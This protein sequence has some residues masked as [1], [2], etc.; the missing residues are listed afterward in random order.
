MHVHGH[1]HTYVFS[2]SEIR[3]QPACHFLDI[4]HLENTYTYILKFLCTYVHV[5][6]HAWKWEEYVGL[7][8]AGMICGCELPSMSTEN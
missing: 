6:V 8:G 2:C 1:G 5:Y 3:G 7:F 4:I